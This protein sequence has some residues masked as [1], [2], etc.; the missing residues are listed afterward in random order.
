MFGHF[1]RESK[2]DPTTLHCKTCN[3]TGHVKGV[4]L[5]TANLYKSHSPSVAQARRPSSERAKMKAPEGQ[6]KTESK[7]PSQPPYP[8]PQLPGSSRQ[9]VPPLHFSPRRYRPNNQCFLPGRISA[10]TPRF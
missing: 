9:M 8:R 3:K 2:V 6:V 5:T 4:C 10:F 1:K 7:E